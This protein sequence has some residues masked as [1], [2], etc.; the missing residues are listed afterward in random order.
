MTAMIL[1][2]SLLLAG[3]GITVNTVSGNPA[4][5]PSPA[6][7]TSSASVC[8]FHSSESSPSHSLST[9]PDSGS[10]EP[11][12]SQIQCVLNH[13]SFTGTNFPGFSALAG[14][15]DG[16]VHVPDGDGGTLT[17]LV[18]SGNFSGDGGYCLCLA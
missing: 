5:S 11:T 1:G 16:P 13:T 4:T 7:F 3:C 17:A 9:A 14:P 10:Q 15:S 18:A 8:A 12:S 6:P 2:R